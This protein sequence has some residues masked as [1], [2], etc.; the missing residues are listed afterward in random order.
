MPSSL[1]FKLMIKAIQVIKVMIEGH[2]VKWEMFAL[3]GG[4]GAEGC[5]G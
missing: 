5:L 1:P 3:G 2:T 4:C